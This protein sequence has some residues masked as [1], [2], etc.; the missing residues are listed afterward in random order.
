MPIMSEADRTQV[1]GLLAGLT[2]PVRLVLFTQSLN[3]ETCAPTRQILDEVAEL[4]ALITVEEHD[5]P[6]EPS[7]ARDL[8]IDR[9][10]AIAVMGE[11]DHGIRFFGL[12]AGYEFSSLLNAITLVSNSESGLSEPSRARLRGVVSPL[13][14]QVFVTPT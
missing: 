14:I 12:P 11:R 3:C 1:R 7:L 5:F 8:S 4:S 2:G 13:N 10:P 9:V 6:L